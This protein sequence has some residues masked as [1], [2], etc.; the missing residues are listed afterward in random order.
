MIDIA[1]S[2]YRVLE[3]LGEGGMGAVYL[4]EDTKLKRNVVLKFLSV[5]MKSDPDARRRF[6]REARAV[7]AL[8][9][10]NVVTLYETDTYGDS[11][12]IVMEYVRGETLAEKAVSPGDMPLEEIIDIVIQ[13]CAGLEEAH[14]AGV[15][16]RDIKPQNILIDKH[17]NVKILD[18][19]LAKLAGASKIT[20]E[21]CRI[22]TTY[23]MSPE[24]AQAGEPDPRTDIW[25]L[26]VVLYRMVTG[27]IPF[28]GNHEI[29][30]VHSIINESPV[31]PSEIR[32]D[33][34][35][36]LEKII[37]KCLRKD[38]DHRYASAG[39]LDAD[40][41]RLRETLKTG[42]RG[43][44]EHGEPGEGKTGRPGEE[45]E[46]RPATVV[47]AEI[48]GYDV[49]V[50]KMDAPEAAALKNR[51]FKMFAGIVEKYGGAF[52]EVVGDRFTAYFGVP[53]AVESAPKKAVNA[54][55]EM[56]NSLHRFNRER[57]LIQTPLA[58]RAGINTGM[59][60]AGT[61]GTAAGEQKD[62]FYTYQVMGD[63]VK[64]ASQ[65]LN[66]SESGQ[67]YV[68]PRTH[69]Y[70]A[71]EFEY[72]EL[73]P[74]VPEGKT[75]PA[76]VFELL[77]TKE[78]TFRTGFG[79]ERM[80]SSEMV[81]RDDQFSRLKLHVLKV[82]HGDGSIISV[83]GEAGIG[84]SRLVAELK[85]IPEM[86][87]IWLLEGRSLSIGKNLSYHPIIDTL[88]NWANIKEEDGEFD[89]L[90]KLEQ[91]IA[92]IYPEG[93]GEVLPFV[94]TL[95]GM[96]L[97]GKHAQ[98][99]KGIEGEAMEKLILKNMWELMRRGTEYR[100]IVFI[101]HDIHWADVSS[102]QL[103]E[104]LF[105]LAKSHP[106]FFINVL[107]PGYID[108]GERVLE[109]IRGRYAG[110]HKELHLEP[111]DE[112]QCETLIRNLVKANVPGRVVETIAA[113]AGGN[114]FF[115]EE[116]LRSFID[117]GVVN[118]REGR[119]E[120]TE[121][122]DSVV[123][124]ETVH[125]VIMARLDRL[126]EKTKSLLKKAAVIG[127]YFFY[128]ILTE[129]T[130]PIEDI[131]TRLEYLK[132]IEFIGERVRLEEVEYLFKHT[133][134]HEV[135]YE[136]IL[137]RKRKALHL[138]VAN[139]IESV[140]SGR[141][142]EFYGMLALHYSRGENL[143]KAEEYL[144]KAG[145]ESLKAAASNEA[146]HYYRE[147]LALYLKKHG[148]FADPHTV[149]DMEKNIATAFYNKG[150]MVEAVEHADKALEL[151]GERLPAKK[152]NVQLRLVY[153]LLGILK[154]L[155]FPIGKSKKIPGPGFND[156]IDVTFK[157]ATALVGVD[158]YRM[159]ADS[160]GVLRKI[161]KFD[162]SKGV[163]GASMYPWGGVLFSLFGLFKIS[164]K[165]LEYPREYIDSGSEKAVIDYQLGRMMYGIFS[166]EWTPDLDYDEKMVESCL[167]LG[168]LY[169]AVVYHI[170]SSI[171]RT[172][173]GD[174]SGTQRCIDNLR[175]I[176]EVYD[177]DLARLR[178]RL[179]V[180]GKLLKCRALP[181]ALREV[182]TG[183]LTTG[184]VGQKLALLN[185]K[186]FKA[187]I[188]ILQG[189]IDGAEK[190]LKQAG[191]IVSRE[192]RITA[193]HISSF[194]LSQFL[195][196]IY[197]LEKNL[198]T[199]DRASVNRFVKSAYRSGKAAVK[200]AEKFAPNRTETFRLMGVF[201]WLTGKRKK[202]LTWFKRSLRVGERLG[203]RPE[204][205]R[206]YMEVG[207]RL[208]EKH[209]ECD[210]LND[211]HAREYLRKARVL[212]K[213]MALHR[214]LEQ[215]DRISSLL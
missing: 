108:T 43:T 74:L 134:A 148:D 143:E 165:L 155:Y 174:F 30:V 93:T 87:K 116:V 207:R 124:P 103:I 159:F 115:I 105:R 11:E 3:K 167:K 152:I 27:E 22:G 144:I 70:T 209:S 163:K 213:E 160:I 193:W 184:R 72:N 42:T 99:V 147:A 35:L 60:I 10:P 21:I 78:K 83:V 146:L 210:Q 157:R 201:Y 151:W 164:K 139:T 94:A 53:T 29:A 114:P 191:E 127:R 37:F 24:Q 170:W 86:K 117:E 101:L 192:T 107:R 195:F 34:P 137:D 199:G 62:F 36:E 104:S 122:I 111:L 172:E 189:D 202:S 6:R 183:I 158:N 121:K 181:E 59:V 40:L 130:R 182:E 50:E 47:F 13:V 188:Q 190:T 65:L 185:L 112:K 162:I 67:V 132:E 41:K 14:R 33:I 177:H 39:A 168:E 25:S 23:Y 204:L 149:A 96:K 46:R 208:L 215:L 109:T 180:T 73:K 51:C 179:L 156:I 17:N 142:H 198:P 79:P 135:T 19:G 171:L 76:P 84:K 31:P 52:G 48:S 100:P 206:T 118:L 56:R 89:S 176:G 214:D 120:I 55:I 49:L 203:A 175:E 64:I 200:T 128:K 85:R 138:D 197:N 140:F 18:F 205:A 131:D 28:K 81:G 92:A 57:K 173:K 186:G 38:R 8:N 82:I 129:V 5:E 15:V 63:T 75:G 150:F 58:L 71:D 90:S 95:M 106:I 194:H 88:K 69:R 145:E 20:G 102:I 1:V 98:R 154:T 166:G 187:N 61:V 119:F 68:G 196:D 44:G 178:G 123:I 2:H 66:R 26:G 126:D 32:S 153:N 212:F 54:A 77:S 110:L 136:S 4:A 12:Y 211:I 113:R 16:H 80:I 133:L 45:T 9:H 91:A 169:I 141:L 125:D 97:R 161:A 7:A